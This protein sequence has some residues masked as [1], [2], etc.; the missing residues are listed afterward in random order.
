MNTTS[1]AHSPPLKPVAVRHDVVGDAEGIL[2]LLREI[3]Y[4]TGAPNVHWI[5]RRS[6]PTCPRG[7]KPVELPSPRI[8]LQCP[9]AFRCG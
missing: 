3:G 5:L 7:L 4:A 2:A 8:A 9:S 1:Y 6:P